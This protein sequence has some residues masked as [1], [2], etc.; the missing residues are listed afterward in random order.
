MTAFDSSRKISL[1]HGDHYCGIYSTEEEHR[2]I[3]TDFLTEGVER[4]EKMIYIIN[5]QTAEDLRARLLET[6]I[7]VDALI[8][9][10]Q[11]VILTT[12]DA[13]LRGGQFDPDTMIS[14]LRAEV[15]KALDDGYTGL[16]ATGE[17]TWALTGEP[18]SERLIEY[19]S[20][21]AE[22]FPGSKCSA[23]CQYDRRRFDSDVLLD[24]VYAHPKVLLGSDSFDNV[25]RYYVPE[26]FR[27]PADRSGLLLDTWLD[28]LASQPEAAVH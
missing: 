10:G 4:G 20:R 9:R 18:G 14:M 19:E 8:R 26:L 3:I 15:Q 7:D 1:Q 13:Y 21:L 27:H 24:T 23:I 11:L 6:G 5:V 28:N 16:R 22:F 12:R 2:T 25:S 17:M